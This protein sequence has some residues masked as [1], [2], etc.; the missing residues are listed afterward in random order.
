MLRIKVW[1]ALNSVVLHDFVPHPRHRCE[2]SVEGSFVRHRLHH[3]D[4]DLWVF[5]LDVHTTEACESVHHIY[6]PFVHRMENISRCPVNRPVVSARFF[7]DRQIAAMRE[8]EAD[9]LVRHEPPLAPVSKHDG[10]SYS[11]LELCQFSSYLFKALSLIH[12]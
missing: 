6:R 2:E 8:V 11:L 1:H 5:V 3:H 10:G 9:L 12:I 4:I 7:P